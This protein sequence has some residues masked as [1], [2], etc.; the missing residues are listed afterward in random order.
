MNFNIRH[1]ILLPL[2]FLSF[3]GKADCLNIVAATI[4]Q[5]IPALSFQRDVDV[6]VGTILW[7]GDVSSPVG[8]AL[9]CSGTVID[10]RKNIVG[11]NSGMMSGNSQVYSTSVP[12]IGYAISYNSTSFSNGRAWPSQTTTGAS[13]ATLIETTSSLRLI[14]TGPITSGVLP[15]GQYGEWTWGGGVIEKIFIANSPTITVLSCSINNTSIQVPL[16]DVFA[17]DLTSVGTTA[18]PKLF[19]V[20]LECEAGAKINAKLTGTQNTDSSV[21]GVLQLTGAGGNNVAN[22]VGIQILYNDAPVVFNNNVVLKTASGGQ[23]TF[24]F[25]AQYYQ[26]KTAVTAGSANATATLEITYQ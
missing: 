12:G 7:Q 9:G 11:S 19:N 17:S 2:C 13:D 23:E 10:N 21:N 14:K 24:P 6:P 1:L 16:E 3:F 25:T 22:G 8:G 18:K 20:G 5:T 4:N 26:T 15:A